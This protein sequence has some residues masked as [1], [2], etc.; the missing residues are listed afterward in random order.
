[1]PTWSDWRT[2]RLRWQ[3]GTL[4]TLMTYGFVEHTR[5]AWLVQAWTY[6]RSLVPLMMIAA[7]SYALALEEPSLHLIWLVI[8]PVFVLDQTLASWKA[9]RRGRLYAASLLPMIVYDMAQAVVN[10]QA[11]SRALHGAEPEWIT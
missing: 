2:Q 4:E 11:L 9:G 7:W 6:F 3:R 1:M 10:W 5:K 8:I